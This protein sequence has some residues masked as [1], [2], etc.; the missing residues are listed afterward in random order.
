MMK[1]IE[2]MVWLNDRWTDKHTL[3]SVNGMFRTVT[4][5][6]VLQGDGA[7]HIRR[8]AHLKWQTFVPSFRRLHQQLDNNNNRLVFSPMEKDV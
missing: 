7:R 6:F 3:E 1:V 4:N 2:W 8:N 5:H